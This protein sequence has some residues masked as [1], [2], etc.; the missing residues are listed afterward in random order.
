MGVDTE[1]TQR[2][3]SHFHGVHPIMM[4]KSAQHAEGGGVHALALYLPSRA[5]LWCTHQGETLP[6]FLLY[7]YMY[8]VGV[9]TKARVVQKDSLNYRL[10]ESIE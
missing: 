8:S 1:Y 9:E 4:V 10:A 2:G 6:L 3:K 5:K 7:S